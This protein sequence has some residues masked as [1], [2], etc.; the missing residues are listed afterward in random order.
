V[1]LNKV[2][3]HGNVTSVNSAL[4]SLQPLYWPLNWHSEDK[5]EETP[6]SDMDLIFY[7]GSFET[8]TLSC[9]VRFLDLCFLSYVQWTIPVR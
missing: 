8:V 7:S 6:K 4:Y 3:V 5:E 1:V 2:K 9:V